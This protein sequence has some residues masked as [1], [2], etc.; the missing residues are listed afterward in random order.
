MV[1][2]KKVLN[3]GG[4]VLFKKKKNECELTVSIKVGTHDFFTTLVFRFVTLVGSG[5]R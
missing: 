5:L 1:K 4:V 2:K 3:M